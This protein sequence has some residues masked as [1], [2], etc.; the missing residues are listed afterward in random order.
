[1][2]GGHMQNFLE[3]HVLLVPCPVI[4]YGHPIERGSIATSSL[5]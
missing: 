2:V 1:M 4:R 5:I 3:L